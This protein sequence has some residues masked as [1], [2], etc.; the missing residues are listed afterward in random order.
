MASRSRSGSRT[1]RPLAA[2]AMII[3][4]MLV[5]IAG[6]DTFLPARWDQQFKVALGL[7]LSGGT[8]ICLLYTSPS[9]RD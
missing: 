5:S 3:V 6:A 8:E 1:W 4:V 9:P 7:D 2:L